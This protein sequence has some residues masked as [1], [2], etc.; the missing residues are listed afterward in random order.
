MRY[1]KTGIAVL[2]VAMALSIF[3]VRDSWAGVRIDKPKIRLTI[4]PG[5]YEAGEIKVENTGKEPLSVRIYLEDWVYVSPDGSKSFKPKGTEKLSCSDWITFYPA[6]IALQPGAEQT[7]RFT[8][9]VPKEAVGGHYSVMFFETG[10]GDAPMTDEEGNDILV[11][12]L[13]R[14]GAL[15]YVEPVGTIQKT[16][17]LDG[18]SIEHNRNDLI[19]SAAFSN[20]GNTDIAGQGTFNVLDAEGYVYARGSFD[21]FYT[22]PGDKAPLSATSSSVNLKPGSYDLLISLDYQ[23]GGAFVQE[24]SFNVGDNGSISGITVKG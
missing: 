12:I 15:F 13:N 14:L 16:A 24:A 10:S 11:K 3:M 5:A 8:V 9:S 2:C 4:A 22:L 20:T 18:L 6:D 1:L 21:E 19:V 7:V 23:T 17:T